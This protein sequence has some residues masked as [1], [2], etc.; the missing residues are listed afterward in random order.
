MTARE[1][2]IVGSKISV[3]YRGNKIAGNV[4]GVYQNVGSR[5]FLVGV[6]TEKGKVIYMVD[7]EIK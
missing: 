5:G 3:M 7:K 4:K 1:K 2:Y 6:V